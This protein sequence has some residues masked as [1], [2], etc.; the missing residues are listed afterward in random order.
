MTPILAIDPGKS[1]GFAVLGLDL[2]TVKAM[3]DTEGDVVDYLRGI[4]AMNPG[5]V[6]YLEK[7]G[8]FAG[9]GQ[10]GSAMFV[11]GRGVG[12]L[13]GALLALG[14]PI[15]A[16]VRPQDWINFHQ[17]GKKATYGTKSAWKNHLKS[18]AQ[19]LYPMVDGITLKTADAILI[20][21]YAVNQERQ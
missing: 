10:P 16:E 14:I 8:G 9:A 17:L 13:V 21:A 19:Q 2:L 3:P 5:L 12:I 18:K 4:Y 11:F 7:V 20:L 1:G 15:K 6:C